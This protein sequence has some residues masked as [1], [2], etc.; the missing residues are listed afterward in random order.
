MDH[1]SDDQNDGHNLGLVKSLFQIFVL[2][3]L[4]LQLTV[5]LGDFGFSLEVIFLD[6]G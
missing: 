3:S 4:K 1:A 6:L 5:K 2:D